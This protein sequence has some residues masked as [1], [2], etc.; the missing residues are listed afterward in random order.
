MRFV[1]S[2]L[3]VLLLLHDNVFHVL[4]PCPSSLGFSGHSLLN[5]APLELSRA[6]F[7]LGNSSG[8]LQRQQHLA[9]PLGYPVDRHQHICAGTEIQL[10]Y[11]SPA[12]CLIISQ[13]SRIMGFE[14]KF[15]RRHGL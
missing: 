7:R 1:F 12:S 2:D 11:V 4:A 9:L 5:G 15:S 6:D 8:H 13:F 14:K 3:R 10:A